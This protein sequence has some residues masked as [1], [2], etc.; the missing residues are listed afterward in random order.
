MPSTNRL[1]FYAVQSLVLVLAWVTEYIRFSLCG[2]RGSQVNVSNVFLT[3]YRP[4][5]LPLRVLVTMG[6]FS[7]SSNITIES[8]V[9]LLR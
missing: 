4:I 1:D 8:N 7:V 9:S 5:H 2:P 3:V 6:T